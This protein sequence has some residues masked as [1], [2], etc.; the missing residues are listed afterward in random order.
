MLA[1]TL[2]PLVLEGGFT[3]S[4]EIFIKLWITI[5][6]DLPSSL[7]NLFS[8]KVSSLALAH[9]NVLSLN[10]RIRLEALAKTTE[11]PCTL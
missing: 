5:P 6:L 9:V 10:L 2:Q 7:M 4:F 11:G 3:T 8:I 1:D